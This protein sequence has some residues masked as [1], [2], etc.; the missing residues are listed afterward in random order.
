MS[1]DLLD[2]ILTM[3]GMHDIEENLDASEI[4]SNNNINN[5]QFRKHCVFIKINP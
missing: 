4:E 3:D 2:E 1:S 5:T